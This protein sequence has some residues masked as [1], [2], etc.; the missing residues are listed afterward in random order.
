MMAPVNTSSVVPAKAGTHGWEDAL[1]GMG[2]R[3]REGD[4]KERSL[5]ILDGAAAGHYQSPP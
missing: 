5:D 3:L 1:A 4:E 2:P